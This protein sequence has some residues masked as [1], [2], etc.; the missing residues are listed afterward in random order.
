M[1]VKNLVLISLFVVFITVTKPVITDQCQLVPSQPKVEQNFKK[2][3]SDSV[4]RFARV[5][6]NFDK[7]LYN[8]SNGLSRTSAFLPR[9]WI[10]LKN[11]E[12]QGMLLLKEDMLLLPFSILSLGSFDFTVNIT[13]SPANCIAESGMNITQYTTQL[14]TLLLNDFR[15][16]V[17]I[18]S[19]SDQRICNQHIRGNDG[20]AEFY[21]RCCYYDFNKVF[22]CKDVKEDVWTEVFF[23][24]LFIIDVLLVLYCPLFVPEVLYREKYINLVFRMELRQP[25]KLKVKKTKILTNEDGHNRISIEHIKADP[26]MSEFTKLVSDMP[27]N[28]AH[29]ITLS[30]LL[31]KMKKP[32]LIPADA[33]PVGLLD[34]LYGAIVLC[35]IRDQTAVK[36]CCY[37]NM[38]GTRVKRKIPWYTC[39]QKLM[40]IL[41]LFVLTFPWLLRV[42]IYYLYEDE[43]RTR[44]FEA[45]LNRGLV[46]QYPG[47]LVVYLTPVHGFFI[48][49]YCLLVFDV[50]LFGVLSDQFKEKSFFVIRK[51]FREMSSLNREQALGYCI[52]ILLIPFKRLGVLFLVVA[53]LYWIVALPELLLVFAYYFMPLINIV[54]NLIFRYLNVIFP[55]CKC[56]SPIRT[57]YQ[58]LY[59]TVN[60]DE[61]LYTFAE[62]ELG[63]PE[64]PKTK[65]EKCV[66][67]V[68]SL[69]LI[70]L[71]LSFTI[72]ALEIILYFIEF[73][74]YQLIGLILFWNEIWK[75]VALI[76]IMILYAKDCLSSVSK[77]YKVFYDK[78]LAF[79]K[80]K[81]TDELNS[82]ISKTEAEQEN[83]GFRISKED[84]TYNVVFSVDGN[85]LHWKIPQ[86]VL[87]VDRYDMCYL[88]RDLFLACA[89]IK[90][91]GCPGNLLS[92]YCK[93][94]SLLLK[95]F[96]FLAFV[97]L[98]IAAFGERYEV[99]AVNQTFLAAVG[100]ILPWMFKNILF[101]DPPEF[102]LDTES[103]LFQNSMD[104]KIQ[105]YMEHA[106][107][108]DI[109]C[110][111]DI[112]DNNDLT[113]VDLEI[114]EDQTN[115]NSD[116]IT[117][118]VI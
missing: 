55:I 118:N 18:E 45:A 83:R 95:I 79:I 39:L 99:S 103:P 29:E 65:K 37:S 100:G 113:D 96:F 3:F 84:I 93:A 42:Y 35:G 17:Y 44:K 36:D 2:I 57:A 32:R 107:I 27:S 26:D 31:L 23:K 33:Y 66:V 85:V 78:L 101:K 46:L 105:S 43:I 40:K 8:L 111:G 58:K 76:F 21:Y 117:L 91:A 75:Y 106:G 69:I 70:S 5:R 7:P 108:F 1:N 59:K 92:N 67:V 10:K 13:E 48:I 86:L 12:T 38:F 22:V 115:K 6:V 112:A 53:W 68:T 80:S 116:S 62:K 24:V 81:V 110:D 50:M 30:S 16:S 20:S 14:R 56:F 89:E 61:V 82:V 98:V 49:M 104:D 71:V 88:S 102:K 114:I 51:C 25:V 9:Q 47:S 28:T 19:P 73:V 97:V 15:N 60:T 41:F 4:V 11:M 109:H 90:N 52:H 87:F 94:I 34:T 64:K 54:C 77:K 63:E 74:F 72:L